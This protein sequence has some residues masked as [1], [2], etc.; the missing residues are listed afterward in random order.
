MNRS[1]GGLSTLSV[2]GDVCLSH[3]TGSSSSGRDVNAHA[4]L[5]GSW[6]VDQEWEI[7]V[8]EKGVCGLRSC[9]SERGCAVD[10]S[11]V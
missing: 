7:S 3:E 9:Y 10:R 11:T 4:Q 5:L 1:G 2:C 8:E 6:V